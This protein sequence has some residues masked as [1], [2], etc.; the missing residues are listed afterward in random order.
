MWIF[1]KFFLL[2]GI[3]GAPSWREEPRPMGVAL[4]PLG[5]RDKSE[6]G[7]GRQIFVYA[8]VNFL[9]ISY[10][11]AKIYLAYPKYLLLQNSKTLKP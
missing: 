4:F 9:A 3:F 11:A 2:W 6:L 7:F 8:S 5:K 1:E 10:I